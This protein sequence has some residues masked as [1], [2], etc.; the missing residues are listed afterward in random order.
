[1]V[2]DQTTQRRHVYSP[3]IINISG[4]IT[5]RKKTVNVLCACEY[6]WQTTSLTQQM[7]SFAQT[8]TYILFHI[9]PSFIMMVNCKVRPFTLF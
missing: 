7:P 9:V 6:Y 3:M 4:S 5:E 1:M 2:N 8:T